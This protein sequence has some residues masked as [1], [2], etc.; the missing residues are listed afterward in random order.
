MLNRMTNQTYY[1]LTH[2]YGKYSHSESLIQSPN[3]QEVKDEFDAAV[4]QT[5]NEVDSYTDYLAIESILVELDEDGEIEEVLDF[6][7]V[8]EEHIFN[9][10]E[11]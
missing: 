11:D 10:Y 2:D 5:L 3:F 6:L 1:Q 4:L 8:I 9:E 7:E